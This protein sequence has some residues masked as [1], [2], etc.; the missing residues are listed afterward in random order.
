MID[1]ILGLDRN[2]LIDPDISNLSA[3]THSSDD[4]SGL[5]FGM[6]SPPSLTR[7]SSL[8]RSKAT[9]ER[10]SA[11]RAGIIGDVQSR[12]DAVFLH[13]NP[14]TTD[15]LPMN[16]A[17]IPAIAKDENSVAEE[18]TPSVE[19]RSTAAAVSRPVP[20]RR[21]VTVQRSSS[22]DSRLPAPNTSAA[23]A[24]P[25]VPPKPNRRRVAMNSAT[26]QSQVDELTDRLQSAVEERD[27]AL[28]RVTEL[29][30]KLNEYY[31]RF[32]CFD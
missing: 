28:A 19:D 6:P 11:H 9:S 3:V 23:T 2:S 5:D 31:E 4:L 17:N 30:A 27:A 29:E 8:S 20:A 26:L 25:T 1:D 12:R 14:E 15:S 21:D 22:F 16:G 32:G 13:D 7:H 24:V 18:R 10:Q